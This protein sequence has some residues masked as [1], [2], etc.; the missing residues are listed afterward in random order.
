MKLGGVSK[1]L[2]KTGEGTDP[3]MQVEVARVTRHHH[4]GNVYSAKIVFSVLGSDI[5]AE[6]EGEDVRAVID[7]SKDKIVEEIKKFKEKK[8]EK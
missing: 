5:R 7:V 8:E 2:G 3:Y 1:F 4:K 6:T